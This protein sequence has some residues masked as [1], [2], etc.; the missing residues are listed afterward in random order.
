MFEFSFLHLDSLS[1]KRALVS[2]ITLLFSAAHPN[3][4]FDVAISGLLS[5]STYIHNTEILAEIARVLKPNGKFLVREP[6]G[7]L[8]SFHLLVFVLIR[9]SF[10]GID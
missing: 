8:P 6:A 5:P 7:E 9:C 4:S 10:V 2:M 1:I 3:S